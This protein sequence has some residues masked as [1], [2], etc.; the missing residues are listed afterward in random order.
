MC[1]A[2]TTLLCMEDYC[3]SVWRSY[4][5]QKWCNNE[6]IICIWEMKIMSRRISF[7]LHYLFCFVIV[8]CGI[9]VQM[10]IKSDFEF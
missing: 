8:D 7:H 3:F 10:L 4:Q 5:G 9:I 2:V 1:T 6:Q